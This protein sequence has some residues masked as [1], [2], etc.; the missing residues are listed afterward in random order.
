[1][2]HLLPVILIPALTLSACSRVDDDEGQGEAQ[3]DAAEPIGS[4]DIDPESGEV[5]ATLTDSDGVT[6]RMLAGSDVEARFPPPFTA[7]PNAQITNT[8]WVEQGEG[9]FVTVEFTTPDP[10]ASVVD[11]YRMQAEDAGIDVEVEVDAGE[12]TTLGGENSADRTSFALQV[13]RRARQT[14]GQVSVTSGL[15]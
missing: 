4:Y 3:E 13:T 10:R 8:T 5:R 15:R 2:R 14:E 12:T 7:Y 11:F 9:A 1:M 6:T